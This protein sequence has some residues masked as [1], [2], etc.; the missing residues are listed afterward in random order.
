MHL[1]AGTALQHLQLCYL[2]YRAPGSEISLDGSTGNIYDGIIATKDAEIAG[3]FGRIMAW[4]DQYRTLK[5]RTNAD[6][7]RDAKKA[8]ELGRKAFL[9]V[10]NSI[11]LGKQ[12]WI[13]K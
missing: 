2:S 7:P 5:V 10:W 11:S 8:R 12:S 13:L 9:S 4:A 6:S 3:E 1:G